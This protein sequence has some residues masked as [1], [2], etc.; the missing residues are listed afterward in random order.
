MEQGDGMKPDDAGLGGIE[1]L[2][3]DDRVHGRCYTDPALFELELERVW[4][5]AWVYAA[6]ESQIPAAGDFVTTFIGREPV[7]ITRDERGRIHGLFN[8]CP[9]RGSLVTNE[10][11]GNTRRFACPYHGWAFR[12]DGSLAGVPYMGGF[13][14]ALIRGMRLAPV[15]R[16]ESYRGWIFVSLAAD[17]PDFARF[18]APMKPGIDNLLDRSPTGEVEIVSGVHRYEYRGNWKMQLENGV[19]EYHPPFSHASSVRKDGG[20]MQRAYAAESWR[21]MAKGDSPAEA[22]GEEVALVG[23]TSH[24][25]NG[26][27]H[28]FGFG[29]SYLTMADDSRK[30][31]L[32][33]PAYRDALDRRHGAQRAGE[34]IDATKFTNLIIY[35]N[36]ISRI[37]GNL[38]IRV[39]RPI[40]VDRTEVWVWPMRIKGAPDDW[41]TGIVKF[42]NLHASVSSFVQ[43]DDLEVFERV[44]QGLRARAPEW[45]QFG[46]GYGRDKPGELPGELW[47]PATWE[48][49][50][51]AQW[52]YWK[53]LMTGNGRLDGVD[54]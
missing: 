16:L 25:D 44:F 42:S 41:N 3:L 52:R 5:T 4:G 14:D 40:D 22:L 15:A 49:G 27:V 53:Q 21:V 48:T 26:Q 11:Q 39:I 8:R 7:I 24:Y 20:Q 6:H 54:R 51:R 31:E 18:I 37:T 29:H 1:N 45:V 28:G 50:M 17:G 2:V 33:V 23:S 43:T 19:D 30:N 9:H 47:G 34:I 35:P 12:M 36:V 46:R 32:R 13:D 10:L 38:H